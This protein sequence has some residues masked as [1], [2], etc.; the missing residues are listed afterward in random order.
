MLLRAVLALA[1]SAGLAIPAGAQDAA[2][3]TQDQ[4]R[5]AVGAGHAVPATVATRAA[6]DVSSGEILRVRLCRHENQLVY[7]VTTLGRDGRLAH[8]TV[9]GSSGKVAQ[10]R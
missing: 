6:R 2:C 9:D 1:V 7:F 3:L 4:I 10:T 8:V 5:D